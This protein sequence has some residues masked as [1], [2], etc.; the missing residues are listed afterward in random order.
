MPGRLNMLTL[1][2]IS[3]SGF[4]HTF[5]TSPVM[6][7]SRLLR[8]E[9]GAER[10]GGARDLLGAAR[11]RERAEVGLLQDRVVH[12]RLVAGHDLARVVVRGGDGREGECQDGRERRETD[13]REGAAPERATPRPLLEHALIIGGTT[14]QRRLGCLRSVRARG[15][16]RGA[17]REG[18]AAREYVGRC[19]SRSPPRARCRTTSGCSSPS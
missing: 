15:A 13:A 11:D 14:E 10:L 4:R 5:M 9:V 16:R 6:T 17:S 12:R 19:R 3:K 8:V 18:V 7:R 1:L 2:R